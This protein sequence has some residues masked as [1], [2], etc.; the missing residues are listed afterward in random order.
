MSL[1]TLLNPIKASLSGSR[2]GNDRIYAEARGRYRVLARTRP[3]ARRSPS[4]IAAR[5][6]RS[7]SAT[8][9]SP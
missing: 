2:N 6:R 1:S 8:P 4:S 5:A 9:F 7:P 3:S